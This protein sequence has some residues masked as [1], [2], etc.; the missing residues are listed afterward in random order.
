MVSDKTLDQLYQDLKKFS[1][2]DKGEEYIDAFLRTVSEII[3]SGDASAL[4]EI[5]PYFDDNCEYDGIF[6]DIRV[7]IESFP[8]ESYVRELLSNIHRMIPKA[9]DFAKTML[10][11]VVNDNESWP[12][13][14][15]Y[16]MEANKNT[17]LDIITYMELKIDWHDH[18]R[19]LKLRQKLER[20]SV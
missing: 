4:K 13:V 6:E 18:A 17:I 20:N 10:A 12:F 14:Q 15:R 7:S 19:S 16:I 3:D 1:N 8:R 5:L 11:R 2:F 9:L